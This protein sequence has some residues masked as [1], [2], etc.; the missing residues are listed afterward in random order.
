MPLRLR[1]TFVALGLLTSALVTA[2][3]AAPSVGADPDLDIN[4]VVDAQTHIARLNQDISVTGG[5][6][7]GTVDLGTGDLTGDLTL[8]PATTQ[9]K[10]GSLPLA[11]VTFELVP[12]GP[13][14]GHVDLSTLTVTQTSTFNI[15]IPS[16]RPVL[17]P[18]NLVGN[19]CQTATPITITMSGP[20][21][22]VNGT[23]LSGEFTIPQFKNCGLLVTPVLNL[24]VPGGG[25]TF[26]A[27]AR[28][29]A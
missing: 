3:V 18:I 4:W 15:R 27:T 7:V 23:T 22:L 5:S 19:R 17:L 14:T 20:V 24:V 10:L 11:N 12:V 16:I 9:L 26:S 1:R 8:P 29:A 6:F 2:V 28:P 13:V 25:N 21:D